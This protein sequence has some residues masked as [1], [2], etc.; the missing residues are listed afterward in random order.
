VD[1]SSFIAGLNKQEQDLFITIKKGNVELTKRG[2]LLAKAYT[3]KTIGDF[4]LSQQKLVVTSKNELAARKMLTDAGYSYAKAVELARDAEI[5]LAFAQANGIKKTKARKKAIK[6]LELALKQ[7]LSAQETVLTS[8]ENLNNLYDDVQSK[9]DADRMAIELKF[10]IDTAADDKIIKDAQDKIAGIQYKLDD[11]EAGLTLISDKEDVINEKYDKRLEALNKIKSIN[12]G[13]A[14]QQKNQLSLAQALSSG[15]I[16]AAANAMQQ[17]QQ[18]FTSQTAARQQD[19]I[20]KARQQEL[21]GVTTLINGQL[22]TRAQIEKTI[23]DLQKEIFDLEEKSVEPAEER[24]RLLIVAR[25]TAL[26]KLDQEANKWEAVKNKIDLAKG[27]VIDYAKELIKANALATAAVTEI[28]KPAPG[29]PAAPAD[30]AA[31]GTPPANTRPGP[32]KDG[33]FIGQLGPDKKFIWDGKKWINRNTAKAGVKADGTPFGPNKPGTKVGQLGPDG[34]Y[35]WDGV[36]WLKRAGGGIIPAAGYSGG[37]KIA[38]YMFNG[39]QP[40]ISFA[41][42]GTDTI[43]AMLTP[44]EFVMSRQAVNNFGVDNMESINSGEYSGGSVYNYSV[45]VNVATNAN[46]N[47]IAQTVMTQIKQIDSQRIRGVGLQR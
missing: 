2:R 12:D 26:L 43:P 46:A 29:T 9:I 24:N 28:N 23:K 10:K 16:G 11:Q 6:E 35:I 36:N 4:V 17:M 1:F 13:I 7:G 34:G 8:E 39:G 40:K 15:D 37:G 42:K 21:L 5:Q 20:E 38:N 25:D 44:G 32:E 47:Q 30:P 22:R 18:E 27:S 31:P 14:Q 33:T 45:N 19:L 3:A 41:A